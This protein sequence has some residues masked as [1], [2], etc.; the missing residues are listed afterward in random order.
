MDL[1]NVGELERLL[2]NLI[3]GKLEVTDLYVL[4]GKV[5]VLMNLYKL[6]EKHYNDL[7]EIIKGSDSNE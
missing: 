4:R 3:A 1:F 7:L 6:L 5:E 2:N